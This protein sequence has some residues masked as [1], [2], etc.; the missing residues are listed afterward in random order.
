MELDDDA[1]EKSVFTSYHGLHEFIRMPFGLCNTPA[2]F[3]R[4]MQA[5][6]TGLEWRNCFV[7]LD[8]SL[9]ASRTFDEHLKAHKGSL[10]VV[11]SG[12]SSSQA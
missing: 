4:V 1:C 2:T 8:D 6:T 5:F 11:V 7:Y 12:R 3:Q 9:I 10:R